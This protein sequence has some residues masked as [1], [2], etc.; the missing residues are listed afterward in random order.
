M[1]IRDKEQIEL[2]RSALIRDTLRTNALVAKI[3]RGDVIPAVD[4]P[5]E[6]LAEL[7]RRLELAPEILRLI[8]KD[9]QKSKG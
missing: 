3:K 7:E 8:G 2:I 4:R 6:S 1:L 9:R 5:E